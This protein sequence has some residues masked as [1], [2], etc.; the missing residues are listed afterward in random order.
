MKSEKLKKMEAE[1]ADL[2]QWLTLGLVPKKDIEKHK[3]E[4]DAV[5]HKIEEEKER[6][7]HIR[8]S[9]DAEE[10]VMPKRNQGKMAYQEAH[11]LPDVDSHHESEMTDAGL[12]IESESYDTDSS[13]IFDLDD[14][15]ED[16]TISEEDD[17]NPFSD[18]NRWRRG[19]LEDPESNDW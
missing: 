6:L 9:G 17:E 3:K 14:A 8:E 7:R 10:Y 5:T 18:R 11:S 15:T 12:D 4:I 19:I 16:R 13:S 2:R 1:L